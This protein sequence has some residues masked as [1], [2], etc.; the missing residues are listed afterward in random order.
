M[1]MKSMWM[2]STV[3]GLA[4]W[5]AVGLVQAGTDCPMGGP[6]MGG[7]GARG[8][9]AQGPGAGRGMG[10]MRK[11]DA[12]ELTPEQRQQVTA[13]MTEQRGQLQAQRHAQQMQRQALQQALNTPH[14][15]A[16]QIRHMA[17]AKGRSVTDMIMLRAA[18]HR[19]LLEILTPEQRNRLNTLDA[20]APSSASQ[21]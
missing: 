5:L 4:A 2:A 15:D 19:K 7:P 13:L 11:L 9:H 3:L 14:F 8:M 16:D 1:N 10:L 20:Q 18:F 12:L 17:E 21:G 6:G